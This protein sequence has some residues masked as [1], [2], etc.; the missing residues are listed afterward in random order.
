MSTCPYLHAAAIA[1]CRPDQPL[2][3]LHVYCANDGT[4]D[5]ND[6]ASLADTKEEHTRNLKKNVP[7]FNFTYAMALRAYLTN[8]LLFSP[9]TA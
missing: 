3:S 5:R 4:A 2:C 1:A 8:Y 9:T 6:S 7:F